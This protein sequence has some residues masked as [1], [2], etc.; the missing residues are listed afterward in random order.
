VKPY[1]K[2]DIQ[3]K[4]R[5]A[6]W[7][8]S[9]IRFIPE[10]ED[11]ARTPQPP[12]YHAEGDAAVHTQLAVEACPPDSDPDLVWSALL[13]DVGKTVVT[14][15]D[16][17]RITAHGH[18]IIGAEM[19]EKIL[20]RLQMPV[21]RRTRIIWAVRH[22]TFHLSWNL[23]DPSQATRRQKRLVADDRFPLLLELLRVDSAASLGNP[24]GMKAYRLYKQLREIVVGGE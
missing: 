23:N 21:N 9:I 4:Q 18:D 15:L 1:Q 16:E 12:Q 20:Q 2:I 6:G 14:K 22:H 10:L 5:A 8:H 19:A 17:D 24:R 7:W 3:I 13:H 11:L